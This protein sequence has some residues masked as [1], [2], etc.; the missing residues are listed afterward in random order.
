MVYV[1]ATAMGVAAAF[2]VT[3][4]WF[5][6]GLLLPV[7]WQTWSQ[8]AQGSGGLGSASTSVG[9]G[10]ILL[11]AIVGFIVGFAWSLRRR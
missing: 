6:G 4:V 2:M 10:A 1:K 8:R 3:L 5:V 7:V 11:V 9:V